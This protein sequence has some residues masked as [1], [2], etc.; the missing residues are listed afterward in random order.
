MFQVHSLEAT[1]LATFC[2]VGACVITLLNFRY[3]ILL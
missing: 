3:K 2:L 1:W